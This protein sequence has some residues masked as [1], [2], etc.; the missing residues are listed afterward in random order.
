MS[1]SGV[2]NNGQRSSDTKPWSFS[3]SDEDVPN[4]PI[5]WRVYVVAFQVFGGFPLRRRFSQQAPGKFQG[6]EKLIQQSPLFIFLIY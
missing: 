6:A 2:A 1:H 4:F 5:P 3:H